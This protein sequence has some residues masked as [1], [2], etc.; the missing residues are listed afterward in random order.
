MSSAHSHEGLREHVLRS[1]YNV[2]WHAMRDTA[3]SVISVAE[4]AHAATNARAYGLMYALL[5]KVRGC[6]KGATPLGL[7]ICCGCELT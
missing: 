1:M 7:A 4:Q 2:H 3:A 5:M 6:L